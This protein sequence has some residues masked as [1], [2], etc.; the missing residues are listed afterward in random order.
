MSDAPQQLKD[1]TS[2]LAEQIRREQKRRALKIGVFVTVLVMVLLGMIDRMQRNDRDLRTRLIHQCE[3]RNIVLELQREHYR[4][5]VIEADAEE[6]HIWAN[7]LAELP[8]A[9]ACEEYR[10]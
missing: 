9:Q 7:T 6:R 10:A 1:F 3:A 2:G 4:R 5:L 8:P